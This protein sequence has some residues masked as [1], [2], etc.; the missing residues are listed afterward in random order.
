MPVYRLTP[1][2]TNSVNW[3]R[4]IYCG[5]CLVEADNEQDARELAAKEYNQAAEL[6]VRQEDGTLTTSPW[7]DQA[8]VACE[9]ILSDPPEMGPAEVRR[10]KG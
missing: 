5:Q 10:L 7:P 4:S 8:L 6:S 9:E 3:N 1:I 2:D